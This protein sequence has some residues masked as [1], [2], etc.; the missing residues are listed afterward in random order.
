M[1]EIFFHIMNFSAVIIVYIISSIHFLKVDQHSAILVQWFPDT[2]IWCRAQ[3]CRVFKIYLLKYQFP[4][5][6]HF[7]IEHVT[8]WPNVYLKRKYW[9]RSRKTLKCVQSVNCQFRG[10]RVL[11]LFNHVL[12]RER[13]ALSLYS[14]YGISAF[15]VLN[16]TLLNSF[17]MPF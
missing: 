5:N 15:L 13:R 16:G 14:V 6:R 11:I 7:S 8:S 10:R 4:W 3:I 2:K 9:F 12:L 1:I 17:K